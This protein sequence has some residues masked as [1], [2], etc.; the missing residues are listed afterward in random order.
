MLVTK[1]LIPELRGEF[2]R[3]YSEDSRRTSGDKQNPRNSTP[4]TSLDSKS[5]SKFGT[6]ISAIAKKSPNISY[7]HECVPERTAP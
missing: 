4:V 2:I 5:C 7:H 6:V 1:K 3:K